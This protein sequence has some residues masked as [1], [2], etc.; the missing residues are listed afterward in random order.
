MS[1]EFLP[2][3]GIRVIEISHMIMGPACGMFLKFLGAEV[4]KIEPPEGDKTRYLT[5]MGRPMFPLFNRGKKSIQLDL[6]TQA[7]QQT[8]DQLLATADVFVENF[9]DSSLSKMGADLDL[10]R[11]KHKQIIIASCKGFLSGPYQNRTALDEVVQ[12]MTGL[13]YMT[14]PSGKPLRAGASVNDIM[15]GLFAAFSVLAALLEKQ[16]TG[17]GTA[18]RV[19]LFENSLLLVAQHMVQ[20]ALEGKNPPPMPERDFSWPVYDIFTDKDDQ[21]IFIAAVT[22]GQWKIVCNIL[23]LDELLQDTRLQSRPDQIA[24][25][26]WTL[27]LIAQK[28]AQR[29]VAELSSLFEAQGI[30][31]SP[32]AKPSDM[33]NDPH[34]MQEGAMAE[35]F[36]EDGSSFKAPSLPFEVNGTMITG[37]GNVPAK[38]QDTVEIL[39]E[40]G[41]S[42]EEIRQASGYNG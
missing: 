38:G 13:A 37:G 23:G 4:I 5:G 35:S 10:I 36:C 7:G 25:R 16:K 15:G 31:F 42:K 34:A 14:G 19:G 22:E 9:R 20:F 21:Q 17:E 33:Y 26:S 41:L 39:E 30:P 32:I 2:L 1:Q 28:V 6:T 24:A 11:K 3:Q 40:L 12:M 8:L 27:P 29:E 18:I